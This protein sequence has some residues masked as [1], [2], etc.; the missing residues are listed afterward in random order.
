MDRGDSPWGYTEK[1]ITEWLR[2][3]LTL[4]SWLANFRCFF[5]NPMAYD[6]ESLQTVVF[7]MGLISREPAV[8]LLFPLGP[9][10]WV[11]PLWHGPKLT[12]SVDYFPLLPLLLNF[13]HN[14]KTQGVR[15]YTNVSPPC[16]WPLLLS[17]FI[18]PC[19]SLTSFVKR[20][21][22][23]HTSHQTEWLMSETQ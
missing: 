7:D 6:H 12:L 20:K 3:L 17:L 22:E 19:Y 11:P 9:C 1:D 4:V 10:S 18:F 21:A 13:V 15:R 16:I 23:G 14:V 5:F 2:L 8:C